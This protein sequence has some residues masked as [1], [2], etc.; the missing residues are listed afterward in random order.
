MFGSIFHMKNYNLLI[1]GQNVYN[2]NCTVGY[3]PYRM[4]NSSSQEFSGLMS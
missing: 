3:G 2:E 1:L 4:D